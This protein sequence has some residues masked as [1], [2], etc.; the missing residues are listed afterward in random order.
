[1]RMSRKTPSSTTR[2]SI[3]PLCWKNHSWKNNPVLR[4]LI[5]HPDEMLTSVSLT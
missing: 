5:P 3:P 4:P 2:S 1:M